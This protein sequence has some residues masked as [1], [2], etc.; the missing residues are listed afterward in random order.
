MQFKT[1]SR[2]DLLLTSG[3]ALAGSMLAGMPAFAQSG[4][5]GEVVIPWSD[6]P[7]PIPNPA[8]ANLTTWEKLDTWI[9]PN[10]RFFN[11]AHFDRLTLNEADWRLE[12][13]G[14]VKKPMMLTLADLKKRARKDVLFTL[15][16]AGNNGFPWFMTGIGTA[17]W[18][19]TSLASLLQ[20]AGVLDSA[21]EVVF[22]GSDGGDYEGRS[23]EGDVKVLPIKQNFARSMSLADAMSPHNILGYEMNG[24]PLES[25]HGFPCRLI[26][27]GWY[28]IANVKWLK[29]IEVLPTRFMG[30]FMAR[31]Y[32]TLRETKQGGETVW[33]QTSV[34][35]SLIKSAPS[36]VIKRDG[37]YRVVGAAW[38]A[39]IQ[40][41]EV[42][43]DNGPWTPTSID[44]KGDAFTWKFWSYDWSS[45]SAGPHTVT[46]RAIGVDGR[47]QPAADDPWITG[48]HTYWESNQQITRTVSIT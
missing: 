8:V 13:T 44:R 3:G 37:Q 12:V 4:M 48:K 46:A 23:V 43:I 6:Q 33:E 17:K 5:Q 45:P 21:K 11:V 7:G 14:L 32:V 29:R 27:P 31:D 22:W 34:G 26:A 47:I 42:R 2:R 24:A 16:C 40:R 9:T 18:G 25:V 19:G 41:V 38:G 10:D 1:I 36:R 35:P 20:D 28:G 15:E 30:R 39:P